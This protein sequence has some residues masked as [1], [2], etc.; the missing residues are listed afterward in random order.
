MY[1]L[2]ISLVY[3]HMPENIS[4]YVIIWEHRNGFPKKFA[5]SSKPLS[6]SPHDIQDSMNTNIIYRGTLVP[7]PLDLSYNEMQHNCMHI[8]TH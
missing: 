4:E 5:L 3:I 6:K 2:L 1:T 8:C 7:H